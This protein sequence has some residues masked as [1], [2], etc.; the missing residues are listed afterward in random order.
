MGTN[1]EDWANYYFAPDSGNLDTLIPR[2][3]AFEDYKTYSG[4]NKITTQRFTRSLKAFVTLC[5][6]IEELNPSDMCNA[7]NRIVRKVDDVAKDMIY[8]KSIPSPP[9]TATPSNPVETSLWNQLP[10]DPPY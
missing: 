7:Q 10:G 6:Y 5:P 2:E 3:K 9:E 8:L 4:V 1:F